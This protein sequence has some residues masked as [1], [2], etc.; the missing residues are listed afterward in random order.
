LEQESWQKMNYV[1]NYLAKVKEAIDLVD[2]SKIETLISWL[3]E[4]RAAN[5]TIF[6]MGNGGSS[7]T[8]SHWVNDLV[9]GASY[10][11]NVRFK[12]M[13]LNDSVATLT[14][15]SNDVSYDQALVEPLKNFLEKED[16]VIAISGSG[17]SN[18]VIQAIEYAKSIG[19]R[20]VGLTGRDGGKLGSLVDLE[21][22]VTEP[23]MGRIEDVHM[24]I[25]HAVS[26]SFIENEGK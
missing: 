7:S 21:I 11:K 3:S 1:A 24:M 22:R 16:L 26:W 17:N 23:N 13:C 9:K 14:A 2:A 5:Q 20:T 4:T 12:V 10:E 18:N 15:Y 19:A 6:T 25:T 8:A